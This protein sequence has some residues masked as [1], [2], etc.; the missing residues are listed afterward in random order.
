MTSTDSLYPAGSD[1]RAPEFL[2]IAGPVKFEDR[3]GHHDYRAGCTLL[4]DLLA[5]TYAGLA[6]VCDGW[7]EDEGLLDAARSLIFYSGGGGKQPFLAS[8]QRIARIQERVDAGVGMVMLHQ[9]VS[10][11]RAFAEQAARWL[12]GVHVPGVSGRGHWWTYH[13][14]F[15]EHPATRGVRPW[16]IRDGWLNQICFAEGTSGVTPL[17]WAGRWRRG[18]RA[19][20]SA[21][22]VCWAYE[23]PGGGRSFC[24]TGLD[25]HSAW[26]HA[27]LRQVIVN[28]VLWS[29]GLPV[30][31]AG[32]PCSIESPALRSYLTPRRPRLLRKLMSA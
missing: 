24:F 10:F 20:G 16:W 1:P 14:E 29:A 12:G 6:T 32:A 26:S 19:G 9:T 28:G 25:A 23:R 2:L 18:S 11:P 22:V 5:R 21:D 17:V 27:G 4:A 3:V 13:R 8:E 30:P 31:A 7:P 15:P